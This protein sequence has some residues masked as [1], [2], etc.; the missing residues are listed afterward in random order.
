MGLLSF[1]KNIF[2][3]KKVSQE[4]PVTIAP[5]IVEAKKEKVLET[6]KAKKI[7]PKKVK[8]VVDNG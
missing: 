1:L 4:I 5:E 8:K 7:Q 6:P 3:S 2:S